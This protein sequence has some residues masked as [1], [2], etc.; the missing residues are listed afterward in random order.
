MAAYGKPVQGYDTGGKPGAW[1]PSTDYI[2]RLNILRQTNP[3]AVREIE[4]R[5]DQI[6][7]G[8]TEEEVYSRGG[9][10]KTPGARYQDAGRESMSRAMEQALSEYERM[11]GATQPEPESWMADLPEE[12]PLAGLPETEPELEPSLETEIVPEDELA[13]IEAKARR[14][15]YKDV[16]RQR[17]APKRPTTPIAEDTTED[18]PDDVELLPFAMEDIK[19]LEDPTLLQRLGRF[20]G[21]D[22]G[23]SVLQA[24]AKGGQAYMGGRAQ[25]EANQQ[26]RQSQAR[27]NLINALSSRAG[28]RGTAEKPRMGK[29]G[30][31]FGTLA[32]IG[33]GLRE[34][35]TLERERDLKERKL[36]GDMDLRE[37][38]LAGD[39]AARQATADYRLGTL[40]DKEAE[41]LAT[42]KHR[43]EQLRISRESKEFQ[44]ER[45]Q[46]ARKSA[47]IAKERQAEQ[48]A[49]TELDRQANSLGTLAESAGYEDYESWDDYLAADPAVKRVYDRLDPDNRAMVRGKFGI[50]RGRTAKATKATQSTELRQA[51]VDLGS[52]AKTGG[53]GQEAPSLNDW[54]EVN[55]GEKAVYDKL[56]DSGK[57]AVKGKFMEGLQTAV[58]EG[59]KAAPKTTFA[60]LFASANI[61]RGAWDGMSA[62]D[63]TGPFAR[64]FIEGD[65][66]E[67]VGFFEMRIFDDAYAYKSLRDALGLQLASAFNKGRPSD[68]DYV[69]ALKLLPKLGEPISVQNKKW[70][71]L[72][73]LI[74]MKKA[75]ETANWRQEN[76]VDFLAEFVDVGRD[77]VNLDFNKAQQFFQFDEMAIRDLTGT[78]DPGQQRRRLRVDPS[79]KE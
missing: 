63:K 31:L 3:E 72:S 30:T 67:D 77:Y 79:L 35:R 32:D 61:M 10:D 26:M 22:K 24:L 40:E 33:G 12:D 51:V 66:E 58:K 36:A 18:Q 74:N 47:E 42:E 60:E 25:S 29:L 7:A 43:E 73:Y 5:A 9:V 6:Y 44:R 50:S 56:S 54:L 48:D 38:K 57:L 45:A 62:S 13:D 70:E 53:Y 76:E 71:A 69:V 27:A 37:R 4:K 20:A 17:P 55:P 11:A 65:P 15:R 2:R 41:R 78:A 21:S 68:K 16:Y 34:E 23:L 8:Y 59:K 64:A 46:W 49:Q 19:D 14:D 28:A 52:V 1:T 75:A 39:E